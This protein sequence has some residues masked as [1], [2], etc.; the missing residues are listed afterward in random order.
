MII[1]FLLHHFLYSPQIIPP[2]LTS[3]SLNCPEIK[4]SYVLNLALLYLI[5]N[6]VNSEAM[7]FQLIFAVLT[8]LSLFN[9]F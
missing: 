6:S 1:L 8:V 5:F 7:L 4:D 9:A 3:V 2:S